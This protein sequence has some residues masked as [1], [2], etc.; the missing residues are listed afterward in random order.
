VQS[1]IQRWGNSLAVRIPKAFAQDVG[2]EEDSPVEI[3]VRGGALVITPRAPQPLT[4]QQLLG[5]ITDENIHEEIETGA[6]LGN[7]AW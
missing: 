7:E 1:K 4:L 6:A 2:L 3:A 5:G